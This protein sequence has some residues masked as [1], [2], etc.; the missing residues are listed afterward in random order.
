MG[1]KILIYLLLLSY[2]NSAFLTG[3]A[4]IDSSAYGAKGK[5]QEE[6]NTIVEFVMEDCMDIHD[7]TPEDEDDDIP[8][9]AK[10]GKM[11]DYYFNTPFAYHS[12]IFNTERN[13]SYFDFLDLY[14][15]ILEE[16][17]PPP[18]FA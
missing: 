13:T 6:Y 14:E 17:S 4:C 7:A 5:N 2:I 1:K 10:T 12:L 8:D 11:L 15:I 16:N 9:S 18:K 3:E